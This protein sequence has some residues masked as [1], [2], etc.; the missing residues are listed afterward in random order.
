MQVDPHR[1]IGRIAPKTHMR[2]YD[3]VGDDSRENAVEGLYQRQNV[4][5]DPHRK[6]GRIAPKTHMREYDRVGDDSRE[7]AVEG[8]C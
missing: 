7:N 3:R 5:V 2:E 1:K 6:I 4:Q 8:L